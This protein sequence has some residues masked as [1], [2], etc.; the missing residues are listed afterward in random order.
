M[1]SAKVSWFSW[2]KAFPVMACCI[3]RQRA[4]NPDLELG[5]R[6]A[7]LGRQAD[8]VELA[9][10]GHQVLC[11]GRVEQRGVQIE[12]AA[13]TEHRDAGE[14]ER[15]HALLDR[16]LNLITDV[17]CA[18]LGRALIE[19]HLVA[20]LGRRALGDGPTVELW[21]GQPVEAERRRPLIRPEGLAVGPDDP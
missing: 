15:P 16:H 10:L 13:L 17:E 7:G 18:V 6:D 12:S 21:F 20:R 9:G 14:R 11:G 19:H 4:R 3:G 2:M 5:L 8:E 1:T